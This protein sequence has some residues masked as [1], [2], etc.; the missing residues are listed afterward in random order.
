MR[1]ILMKILPDR[2]ME[3]VERESRSWYFRCSC[4]Q[5]FDIW[6]MG[7]IRYKAAGNPKRLVT[8]PACGNLVVGLQKAIVIPT[9]AGGFTSHHFS[10]KPI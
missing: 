4:G 8:C 1:D 6:S 9:S 7:G 2:L 10:I 5:E 3:Q